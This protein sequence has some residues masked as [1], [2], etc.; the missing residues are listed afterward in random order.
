MHWQVH[1]TALSSNQLDQIISTL[2]LSRGLTSDDQVHQFIYPASPLKLTPADVGLSQKS[3]N[4]TVNRIHQ[5]VKSSTPIIIYGDYDADGITATAI[6]W[7]TLHKL[8]ATATPFIPSREEHGYGLSLAGIKDALKNLKSTSPPLFITVDNG[9]VAHQAAAH[10]QQLGIDLIITDHHQLPDTIPY[11]IELVHSTAISGAGVAWML[12]KALDPEQAK[13]TLDLVTIGTIAD[14]LPLTG[15]NRRLAVHGLK[16]LRHTK[17]VG[18]YAIYEEAGIDD[19]EDFNAYHVNY[20]I[21]PRL[22]AMGRLSHALDSLRLLCTT[23]YS[24]A[25]S[26]ARLLSSTNTTRQSLTIEYLDLAHG[27]ITDQSV[28]VFILDH[29]N[30]HEGVIGLVAGKLTETFYRPSI[31]ISRSAKVSKGSARSIPEV[32]IIDAIRKH[33]QLL[34]N[35]GG[36]PMAAGFSIETQHIKAFKQALTKTISMVIDAK[37]LTPT[38][39]ID[40]QIHLDNITQ[41]LFSRLEAFKP[42]GTDNPEPIFCSRGVRV[43]DAKALGKNFAHLR[44]KLQSQSGNYYSA[45]GF[46]LAQTDVAKSILDSQTNFVDLAYHITENVWNGH[47]SLQ[48]K[49]KDINL[50]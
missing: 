28:P 5:A 38:L 43:V 41:E 44:L 13:D 16:A 21:A 32:N 47:R 2:Y 37:S 1:F 39:H 9:V 8:G 18:L 33:Q 20:I 4:N 3:I 7:E 42:F 6:L 26:L 25:Q 40:A 24:R 35:A 17:R 46:N 49:L 11:C 12:S 30:F 45:I 29:E 34:I 14:M 10:L 31:V 23:D 15:P 22:N 50:N 27:L 19:T 36:H 48:L